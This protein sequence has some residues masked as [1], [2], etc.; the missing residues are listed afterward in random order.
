MA[1]KA[2]IFGSIGTLTETSEL[3]REAFNEAFAKAGLNWAWDVDAYAAMVRQGGAKGGGAERISDYAVQRG[4]T[5]TLGQAQALHASKSI[6]FQMLMHDRG[7]VPNPGVLALMADAR[8]QGIRLVSASST[9]PENIAAMFAATAPQL[10][11]AMFDLV[12][13]GADV[14]RIKPA[15]DIYLLALDRLKIAATDA[16]AIEDTLTSIP[17]ATGAGIKVILVPGMIAKGQDSGDAV[18]TNSLLDIKDIA[19]IKALLNIT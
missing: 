19:G 9:S 10:T 13:T 4:E 17:A 15:P 8:A 2:L 3:Q 11:P 7:L 14:A 16:V 18:V 5:L 12:L 1:L 6:I